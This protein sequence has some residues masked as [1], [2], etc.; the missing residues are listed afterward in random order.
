[1]DDDVR[2]RLLF[3]LSKGVKTILGNIGFFKS[4]GYALNGNDSR[5]ECEWYTVRIHEHERMF[6][7]GITSIGV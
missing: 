7:S 2:I 4:Y 1:M 3:W 6:K 5:I